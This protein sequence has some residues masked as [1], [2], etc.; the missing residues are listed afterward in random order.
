[1]AFTNPK[2]LTQLQGQLLLAMPG[3]SDPLFNSSLILILEH[4]QEGAI[5]L[6]I[7]K[8]LE[9]NIDE[10]LQQ[11]DSNYQQEKFSENVLQGGPVSNNRGFVLHTEENESWQHQVKLGD[12][13]F[14]T[15]S[16]DI[17]EA[18]AR[19]ENIGEFQLALGYAGWSEG[20]LEQE[21]ADNA[22]LNVACDNTILF[23]IASNQRL[24]AAAK[25]LGIDYSL[26]PSIG[27]SA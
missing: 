11:I 13:L 21:M 18:I 12:N 20:Q 4:N 10:V 2:V 3:L 6:I 14:L 7:N 19:G 5:G 25:K 17:L 9:M 22:W 16:T 8:T 1:M 23:N 24:H 15:T 26:L 27:G